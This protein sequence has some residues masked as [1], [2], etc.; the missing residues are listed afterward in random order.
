MY[1]IILYYP[2]QMLTKAGS[3]IAIVY[4]GTR[5]T[6][7]DLHDESA[8]A[9][10]DQQYRCITVKHPFENP[11]IAMLQTL[12][13]GAGAPCMLSNTKSRNQPAGIP[14][15]L[16]IHCSAAAAEACGPANSS[17]F[18]DAIAVALDALYK[19]LAAQEGLNSLRIAKR[20]VLVSSFAS[21]VSD[22]QQHIHILGRELS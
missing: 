21:K 11:G 9:G 17:D 18:V 12:R 16:C 22:M 4:F 2:P 19:L 1:S 13:Q 3:L 20:V 15:L 7:N 10:D 6:D 5:D 14:S 8:A